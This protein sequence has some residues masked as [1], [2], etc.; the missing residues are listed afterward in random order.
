MSKIMFL[1]IISVLSGVASMDKM[2]Q[3]PPPTPPFKGQFSK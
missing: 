3:L 1:Y 2:E